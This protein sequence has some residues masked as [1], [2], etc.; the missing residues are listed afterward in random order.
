[1]LH[2]IPSGLLFLVSLPGSWVACTVL[3]PSIVYILM[4]VNTSLHMD[5]MLLSSL[6]SPYSRS[7]TQVLLLMAYHSIL[8]LQQIAET[9]GMYVQ[10]SFSVP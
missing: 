2:D 10:Y 9:S 4:N 7:M 3:V 6:Q 8:N 5:M 1:M